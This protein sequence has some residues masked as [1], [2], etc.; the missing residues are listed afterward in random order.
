MIFC[1]QQVPGA[2]VPR[3]APAVCV[4]GGG[5]LSEEYPPFSV[6]E[7]RGVLRPGQWLADEGQP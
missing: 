5:L 4:C 1:K 6:A 7:G 2:P 3:S